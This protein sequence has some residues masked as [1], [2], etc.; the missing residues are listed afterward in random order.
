[1]AFASKT[2]E[3]GYVSSHLNAQVTFVTAKTLK[4]SST[5]LCSYSLKAL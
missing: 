1:M 2:L 3:M 4:V 5:L